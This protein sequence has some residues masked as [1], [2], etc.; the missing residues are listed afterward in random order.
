M[1]YHDVYLMMIGRNLKLTYSPAKGH[2]F[3]KDPVVQS[4]I[5]IMKS[6]ERQKHRQ[7]A[8]RCMYGIYSP[9]ALAVQLCMPT[10]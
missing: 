3:L 7:I 5:I 10:L 8:S 9:F 1:L 2:I 4:L 6:L